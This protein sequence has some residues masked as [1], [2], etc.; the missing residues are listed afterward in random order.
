MG[1]K[2]A[3]D[4]RGP[5][6]TQRLENGKASDNKTTTNQV[7]FD[8][9]LSA[10]GELG[11][12]QILLF[13]ATWPFYIYGVFVY[14]SQ[15]FITELPLNYWCRIPELEHLTPIERRNLAIPSD[16][17]A[18]FG[19]SQCRTYDVNWTEALS[20]GIQP[21]YS[22]NTIPCR[23]GWEFN[24]TEI[25]YATISSEMGWVCDKDS[26]QATAQCIFF[27][28][29]IF[30]GIIIGWV[31][32]RFG[33]IPAT[34][35]SNV[36]GCLGG[37]ISIYARSFIEFS[38]CRFFMG[39]AYDN[40]FMMIYLLVLEYVAPRYRTVM[41]NLSFSIFYASAVVALP[42]IA[43]AAGH[44]KM[45]SLVTSLPMALAIFTPLIVPE[46]PRW[47]LSKGRVDDAV[48]KVLTIGRINK[49]DLPTKL[50]ERFKESEAN[51]KQE[52]SKSILEVLKRPV[53]RKPFIL[54][55]LSYICCSMVFDALV[56]SIGTLD[57]DFFISFSVVSATEFPS[58]LLLAFVM[59]WLGRRWMTTI[60]FTISAIFC[61]LTIVFE[62][63]L[64]AVMCAVVARFM[65]NMA[66][67]AVMQWAAELL[68]T[69]VR[70]TGISVVHICGFVGTMMSPLIVYLETIVYWLPL[71]V[72]GTVAFIGAILAFFL[73]ETAKMDMPQTFDD[74]EEMFK[75]QSYWNFPCLGTK[76]K[77]HS[78]QVND[79]FEM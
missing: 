10:A 11:R 44:W 21:D 60:T 4:T 54:V 49:K 53:L 9:L 67:G 63:G 15:L 61:F 55:C 57:F 74:A 35:M 77:D 47:M 70:G 30:G 51:R 32:D 62:G 48:N 22:W 13:F 58:V 79:C 33:R 65:V 38:L 64:Y 20:T 76:E 5:D 72:T 18:R 16:P 1:L 29:C 28:G 2:I 42:W 40:C 6:K 12:Y 7:D 69:P 3:A 56:R 43:L 45:I 68:P 31:A 71:S 41:A 14:F 24:K 50:I 34:I 52:E 26:Y 73:P 46:S 17:N 78:G 66:Y 25:P 19:Y 36:I 27:L 39:M 75:N 37:V 23:N 59:D 8:D